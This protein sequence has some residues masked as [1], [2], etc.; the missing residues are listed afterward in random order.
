MMGHDALGAAE[1]STLVGEENRAHSRQASAMKAME[2]TGV[3][4][5]PDPN[6]KRG[7]CSLQ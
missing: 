3:A 5:T 2:R 6:A 4:H 7:C 1:V